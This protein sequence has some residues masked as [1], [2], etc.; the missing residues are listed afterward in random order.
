MKVNNIVGLGLAVSLLAA[1]ESVPTAPNQ[2]EQAPLQAG[3]SGSVQMNSQILGGTPL[4]WDGNGHAYDAIEIPFGISW[5]TARD[6]AAA[7][8]L[9]GCFGHL[10]TLTS[11]E[12]NAFVAENLS[13]ALPSGQRG[14]WIGALQPPGGDEPAGGW[15]W[16]TGE[17]FEFT[18]WNAPSEPNNWGSGE[19]AVHLWDNGAGVWNDL[20]RF[21]NT[22]GYVVEFASACTAEVEEIL[23][24][25]SLGGDAGPRPINPRSWGVVTVVVFSTATADGDAS[26]FDA[27]DIDPETVTLGDGQDTDAS[28]ARRKND[29]FMA[30][31]NDVDEDGDQDMVFQFRI[32]DIVANGDLEPGAAELVLMGETGTG[33][34]FQSTGDIRLVP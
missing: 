18:N 3:G 20:G 17:P 15:T 33:L 24:G 32:R 12:E 1:C 8:Q 5:V 31:T 29:T 4:I 7:S 26:D 21:D 22:P 9:D 2:T 25:I 14:F 23:V 28:V 30:R 16:V 27:S 13:Q 10:A 11:A 19:D 6:L 34:S